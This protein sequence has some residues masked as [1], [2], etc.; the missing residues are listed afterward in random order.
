MGYFH[1]DE[2]V[3]H[4]SRIFL[5]FFNPATQ[6]PSK[7]EVLSNEINVCLLHLCLFQ[8]LQFA[9]L[10]VHARAN[11]QVCGDMVDVLASELQKQALATQGWL[12]QAYGCDELISASLWWPCLLLQSAAITRTSRQQ[13]DAAGVVLLR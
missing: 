1:S 13:C 5:S 12:Q 7:L 9:G 11:A 8:H 4:E 10:M 6:Q 3:R 2:G